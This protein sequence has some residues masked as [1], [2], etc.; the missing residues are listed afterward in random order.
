MALINMGVTPIIYTE[1]KYNTRLEYL[2]EV[3]K[4]KVLYHFE[5]VDI[6]RAKEVLGGTAAISGNLPIYL[7]EHGTPE[8]VREETKSFLISACREEDISLTSTPVSI[9]RKERI[10]RSCWIR[11]IL[12]DMHWNN[13]QEAL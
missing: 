9:W 3:P 5:T 6:R 10:W 1:G 13:G 11:S 7:M 8:Q 4:G 12:S 2:A